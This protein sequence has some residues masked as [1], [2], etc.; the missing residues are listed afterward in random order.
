MQCAGF[1]DIPIEHIH[2][3]IRYPRLRSRSSRIA[4]LAA[5]ALDKQCPE[6]RALHQRVL[7]LLV[8]DGCVTPTVAR[9]NQDQRQH[10]TSTIAH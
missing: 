4:G 2:V 9:G 5:A 8:R 10:D 1:T 7:S 3:R 6:G